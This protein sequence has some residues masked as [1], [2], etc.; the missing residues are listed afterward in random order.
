MHENC[1]LHVQEISAKIDMLQSEL[2][3]YIF[4][5]RKD[6][7]ALQKDLQGYS[8]ELTAVKVSKEQLEGKVS[9]LEK[10]IEGKI[11]RLEE[12]IYGNGRPGLKTQVAIIVSLG[13]AA[14]SI[15]SI[16][17]MFFRV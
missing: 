5:L 10:S 6:I 11:S 7:G 8:N 17:S 4:E 9:S 13:M 2:K 3:S 15:I 14:M 12:T 16:L 1:P